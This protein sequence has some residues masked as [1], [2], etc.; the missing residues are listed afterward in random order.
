MQEY[1]VRNLHLERRGFKLEAI[2]HVC[3]VVLYFIYKC[4]QGLD[5]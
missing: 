1:L 4:V 2:D 3:Q 5:Y